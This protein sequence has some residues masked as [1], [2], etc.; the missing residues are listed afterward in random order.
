MSKRP[1]A[2]PGD[3]EEDSDDGGRWL[4]PRPRRSRRRPPSPT[5]QTTQAATPSPQPS[6]RT[7]FP[8]FRVMPSKE[9]TSYAAVAALETAHPNLKFTARPNHHGNFVLT[10]KSQEAYNLLTAST[11]NTLLELN[12][13]E[14]TT[15]IIVQR[16]PIEMNLSHITQ[17]P[18]VISAERCTFGKEKTT[19]RQ[20]LAVI[21]GPVPDS[22]HLGIWGSF[23]V[24]KYIPEP[25][26]C[27][28][29]QR[30]GHH[31]AR[32]QLQAVCAVCS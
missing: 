7:I 19:T 10:P 30:Y 6:P 21:Q 15:K 8:K 23:Q 22:L 20:V 3:S 26:R 9:A 14:R 4:Q 18:S 2:T 24:R 11:S 31:Q 32:C 16:Y 28:N 29:C 27:Y 13:E 17:L 25:L 12:P 1:R 5:T